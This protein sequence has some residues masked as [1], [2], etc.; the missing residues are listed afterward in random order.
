M[1]KEAFQA[2]NR[3]IWGKDQ[4]VLAVLG[5]NKIDPILNYFDRIRITGAS[6]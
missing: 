1:F 5:Q 6:R 3:S 4:Q 2:L